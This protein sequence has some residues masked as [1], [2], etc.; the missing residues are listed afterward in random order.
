MNTTQE[1]GL[2]TQGYK[3]VTDLYEDSHSSDDVTV[4][5]EDGTTTLHLNKYQ[6]VFLTNGKKVLVKDLTVNDDLDVSRCIVS[7]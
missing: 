7:I 3:N 5:L 6:Y 4:E 1:I 2:P